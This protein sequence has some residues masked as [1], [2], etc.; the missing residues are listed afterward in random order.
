MT[1]KLQL[2]LERGPW[3]G[4]WEVQSGGKGAGGVWVW[5]G[6]ELQQLIKV[7]GQVFQD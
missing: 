1:I 6:R 4:C 3:Q 5:L 7:A 2:H